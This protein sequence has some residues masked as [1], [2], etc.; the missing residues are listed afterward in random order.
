MDA[1]S[2]YSLIGFQYIFGVQ[3]YTDSQQVTMHKEYW[4]TKKYLHK[5]ALIYLKV[6]AH[7]SAHLHKGT[8]SLRNMALHKST[9]SRWR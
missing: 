7:K 1:R 8:D 2:I 6:L 4:F 9:S 3:N 5:K